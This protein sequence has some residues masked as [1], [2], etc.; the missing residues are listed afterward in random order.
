MFY[1]A[2]KLFIFKI[3][4]SGTDIKIPAFYRRLLN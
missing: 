2:K 3:P 4:A 1:F